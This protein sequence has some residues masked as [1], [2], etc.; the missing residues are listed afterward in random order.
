MYKKK[1]FMSFLLSVHHDFVFW[2]SI[3]SFS[4]R[5][6]YSPSSHS[7]AACNGDA[8]CKA[9]I[10]FS[11]FIDHFSLSI[12]VYVK[13]NTIIPEICGRRL[14]SPLCI[15]EVQLK[16]NSKSIIRTGIFMVL[17]HYSSSRIFKQATVT[18]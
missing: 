10:A 18:I 3:I 8:L 15:M 12:S 5:E 4:K 2:L 14:V 11:L 13:S 7:C 16:S 6:L 9:N 1:R 17:L